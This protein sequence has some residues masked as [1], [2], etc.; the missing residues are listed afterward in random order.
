VLDEVPPV[1]VSPATNEPLTLD[2]TATPCKTF[3][4]EVKDVIFVAVVPLLSYNSKVLAS[5]F[6]TVNTSLVVI[7]VE[8]FCAEIAL[9]YV[10]VAPELPPV[11]VS[12]VVN[13]WLVVMFK[14]VNI[15]TSNR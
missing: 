2:K 9:N 14:W 4:E 15:L 11:I 5:G 3:P 8:L 13:D 12:P 1:I 10:P 7:A 6:L